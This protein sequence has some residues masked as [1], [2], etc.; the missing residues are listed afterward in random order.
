MPRKGTAGFFRIHVTPI[1]ATLTDLVSSSLQHAL[2]LEA[3]PNA[4]A[5]PHA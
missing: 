1:N 2:C 4:A 3:S 5:R